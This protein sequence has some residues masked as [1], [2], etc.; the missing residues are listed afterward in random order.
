MEKNHSLD[1]RSIATELKLIL[2]ILE[3]N[4]HHNEYALFVKNINWEFFVELA[5]HHRVFPS[6]YLNMKKLKNISL[7]Q[8]VIHQLYTA[9][10]ANTLDMLRLSAE[11]EKISKLLNEY[12]I[13]LLFLKGPV[14]AKELYGDLSMRTSCDIDI[15]IPIGKLKLTEELL[16]KNG[17]VKN[18]Y[19][20]SILGDWKW[21]HHHV[22]Y[23]HPQKDIKVE[24]HWRLNPGPG[25]EPNFDELWERRR[26]SN[27]S[28][29]TIYSLG[30]E[31]LFMFLTSHGSR[32]GWSRIRWLVDINQILRKDIN[33]K[34]LNNLLKKY[35]CL[36]IGGQSVALCSSLLN[37]SIP[38]DLHAIANS[39]RALKLAQDSIFYM[40][41]KVN[42]HNDPV[43]YEI[44]LYHKRHLYSLM[45]LKQK[46]LFILSFL[47]P[48]HTDVETFPLPEKWHFLYFFMRPFLWIWRKT[49]N[50][51]M[52]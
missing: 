15:L 26:N 30:Y 31:D 35:H 51:A 18:D 52:Q 6:L 39:N 33:W 47:Y 28:S 34:V 48:Y 23:H 1:L 29:F 10:R 3:G 36:H 19:I 16:I 25:F 13:R 20:L 17:Y 27:I 42:L 37:T 7:P 4:L 40:E 9:Y 49:R 32:H 50:L 45:S 41:R 24:I 8:H 5:M 21:R 2:K 12:K 38:K 22:T 14:L 43:P 46:S 44:A 11:M